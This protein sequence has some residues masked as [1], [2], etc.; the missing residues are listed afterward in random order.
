MENTFGRRERF[1]MRLLIKYSFIY[2]SL[3]LLISGL[4]HLQQSWKKEQITFVFLSYNFFKFVQT[5][6]VTYLTLT[7]VPRNH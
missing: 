6:H 2:V 5:T 7:V 4:F 3:S 1:D